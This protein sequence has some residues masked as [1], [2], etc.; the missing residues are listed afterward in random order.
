[1]IFNAFGNECMN[2]CL[3]WVT[4]SY[5]SSPYDK[6][7]SMFSS[8]NQEIWSAKKSKT[9]QANNQSVNINLQGWSYYANK[10]I[11][12]YFKKIIET[13]RA[14]TERCCR[15]LLLQFHAGFKKRSNN[16][17]VLLKFSHR[18]EEDVQDDEEE[19]EEETLTH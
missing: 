3:C 17:D 18:R 14:S 15:Q 6:A 7:K 4:K 12:I 9:K 8:T 11:K 13:S 5:M 16:R 19:K 1:M 2:K 10:K